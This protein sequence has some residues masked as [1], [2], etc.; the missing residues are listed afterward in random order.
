MSIREVS[1][2]VFLISIH[3]PVCKRDRIARPGERRQRVFIGDRIGNE[4]VLRHS[5]FVP[6]EIVQAMSMHSASQ[7]LS[8]MLSPTPR[9]DENHRKRE[10]GNSDSDAD[11]C[12]AHFLVL[13]G[14][15]APR[16]T[17]PDERPTRSAIRIC[18]CR[19]HRRSLQRL[20][21]AEASKKSGR[22]IVITTPLA[23]QLTRFACCPTRESAF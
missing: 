7:T 11:E 3:W 4:A 1:G 15:V 9:R 5:V 10:N 14:K 6:C 23:R 16:T 13:L 17:C 19:L 22:P 18:T 8:K 21:P 2:S 20:Q 12:L